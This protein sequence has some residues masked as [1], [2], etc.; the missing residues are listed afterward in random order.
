MRPPLASRKNNR[1]VAAVP[2]VV[3]VAFKVSVALIFSY[4]FLKLP[5]PDI[6]EFVKPRALLDDPR[7]LR[8]R[9]SCAGARFLSCRT[10]APGE[11][12]RCVLL[13]QALA[14]PLFS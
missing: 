13:T 11:L 6:S 5:K 12:R 14:L 10:R 8:S 2:P 1:P 3:G 9:R 7:R 4:L